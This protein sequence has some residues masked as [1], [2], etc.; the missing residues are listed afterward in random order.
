MKIVIVAFI[1]VLFSVSLHAQQFT[2]FENGKTDFLIRIQ[3][4]PMP[5]EKRAADTLKYYLDKISGA[6]FKI[7]SDPPLTKKEISV[8]GLQPSGLKQPI[9]GDL[10]ED[11]SYAIFISDNKISI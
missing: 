7:V 4:K 1:T 10:A 8:A 9:F 11:E 3:S 5:F 2:L 6:D